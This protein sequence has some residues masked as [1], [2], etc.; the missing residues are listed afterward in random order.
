MQLAAIS[1]AACVHNAV[2]HLSA[3]T[4]P[5][6]AISWL[7]LVSQHMYSIQA[8]PPAVSCASGGFLARAAVSEHTAVAIAA[9][10]LSVKAQASGCGTLK[11]LWQG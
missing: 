2:G 11:A 8:A 3:G 9:R 5:W 1:G 4:L 6:C 7:L 10:Q